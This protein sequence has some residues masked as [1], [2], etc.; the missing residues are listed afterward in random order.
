[1]QG[2]DGPDLA[3]KGEEYANVICAEQCQPVS[4]N[5]FHTMWGDEKK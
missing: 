2:A 3:Y 5:A 4:I 1:M